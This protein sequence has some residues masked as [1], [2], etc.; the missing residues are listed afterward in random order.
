MFSFRL[1]T[2]SRCPK[3]G[4]RYQQLSITPPSRQR[5]S[6]AATLKDVSAT[7]L[8]RLYCKTLLQR[9]SRGCIVRRLR[10]A[11]LAAS[12]AQ[13]RRKECAA[14]SGDAKSALRSAETQRVRCARRRRKE[15]A[16]LS[17]SARLALT[18]RLSEKYAFYQGQHE[19]LY[20]FAYLFIF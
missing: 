8:S 20:L 14:L 4:Q 17:S 3:Q 5:R 16:A 1:I 15:C 2:F 19:R 9:R 13:R 11:A 10:N 12:F 7:P 18:L 6:F